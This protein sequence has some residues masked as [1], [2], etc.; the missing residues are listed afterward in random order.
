MTVFLT[1][2]KIIG[3]VLLSILG[4]LLVLVLLLLFWPFFYIVE[5]AKTEEITA[6]AK[7][8]WLLHIVV[9]EVI[10]QNGL[11]K[12]LKLFGIPVYDQKRKEA[13]A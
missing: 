5:A 2:L 12:R 11:N 1:V 4:F 10:W 6:K 7:V 13:K 3:I 9:V 8:T